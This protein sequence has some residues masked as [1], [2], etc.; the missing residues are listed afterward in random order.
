MSLTLRACS[1]G[2]VI[3]ATSVGAA[4]EQVSI[5]VSPAVSFAPA[6]LVIQT[7]IEP[8]VNNRAMAIVADSEEFYRSSLIPLEGDGAPKRL[9]SPFVACRGAS[10]KSQSRSSERT[11][12]R[13]PW[14]KRA[15]RSSIRTNR[16][17]RISRPAPITTLKIDAPASY[18]HAS[19][20]TRVDVNCTSLNT[21]PLRTA[22]HH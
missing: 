6:D 1:I 5:R 11:V 17:T 20:S 18:P 22:R 10:T 3:S 12:V 16:L 4:K 15:C 21:L 13:G 8:D 14:R 7:R 19:S 9:G 2:I